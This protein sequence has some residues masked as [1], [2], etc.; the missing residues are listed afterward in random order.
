MTEYITCM[1]ADSK[2][3]QRGNAPNFFRACIGCCL[4]FS[5]HSSFPE[6]YDLYFDAICKKERIKR[7]R[8][9]L[10]SVDLS[11]QCGDDRAKYMRILT[12]F[13][14]FLSKNGVFVNI[15]F[16]YFV[17]SKLPDGVTKYGGDRDPHR[18]I[19]TMDFVYELSQYYPYISAWITSKSAQLSGAKIYL[20]NFEGEITNSWDELCAHHDVKVVPRGDL[21][22]PFISSADIVTKYIDE[23]LFTN[24]L[25]LKE[26]NIKSALNVCGIANPHVFYVGH[27]NLPDIVPPIKK[28]IDCPSF[29]IRPMT[30]VIKEGILNKEILYIENSPAYPKILAFAYEKQTGIRFFSSEEDHKRIRKGDYIIYLGENGKKI[31][32]Y[33]NNLGHG[34]IPV[35]IY[36]YPQQ[37]G[38]SRFE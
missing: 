2:L 18:K 19:R 27:G 13:I 1:A 8:V 26:D 30:F 6:K 5:N 17:L 15:A 31:V 23:Y 28:S 22:N 37:T 24:R 10:K 33:L 32:D 3:L 9:I 14:N 21:C 29:Y 20:D 35:N 16:T 11:R 4:G 25:S 34:I 7:E 38:L 12:D 36:D